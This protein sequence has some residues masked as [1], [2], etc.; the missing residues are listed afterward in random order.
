VTQRP[1]NCLIEMCGPDRIG[2]TLPWAPA[3]VGPDLNR[4]IMRRNVITVLI[5]LTIILCIL[6]RAV[7]DSVDV[8]PGFTKVDVQQWVSLYH[9]QNEVGYHLRRGEITK[10]GASV[11]ELLF[12]HIDLFTPEPD[13]TVT[14]HTRTRLGA[15]RHSY[16]VKR[17]SGEWIVFRETR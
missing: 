15:S 13:G 4:S 3:P 12:Q 7:S 11:A 1:S 16:G 9:G 17:S 5:G 8:P 10:V 6:F 2:F 14:I